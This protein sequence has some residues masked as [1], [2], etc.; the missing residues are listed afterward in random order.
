MN[1]LLETST[2]AG[3]WLGVRNLEPDRLGDPLEDNGDGDGDQSI[4]LEKRMMHHPLP[5]KEPPYR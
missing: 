1:A 2:V 5:S 3:R 4:L